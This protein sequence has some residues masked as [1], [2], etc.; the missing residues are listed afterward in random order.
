V[1]TRKSAT[2]AQA[3]RGM[4]L[5]CSG[6]GVPRAVRASPCYIRLPLQSA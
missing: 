1:R 3:I 2:T 4:L 5:G 6:P